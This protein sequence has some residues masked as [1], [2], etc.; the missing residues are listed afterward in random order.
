[1]QTNLM[2]PV[3]QEKENNANQTAAKGNRQKTLE[4]SLDGDRL[5]GKAS[6]NHV[7]FSTRRQVFSSHHNRDLVSLTEKEVN[8]AILSRPPRGIFQKRSSLNKESGI[9]H[10]RKKQAVESL[11]KDKVIATELIRLYTNNSD[12]R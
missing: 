1:M 5:N 11:L 7:A 8:T 9:S 3:L 6:N 10:S 4:V 12:L 2:K